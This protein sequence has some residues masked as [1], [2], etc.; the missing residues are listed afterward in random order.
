MASLSISLSI[1]VLL[2]VAQ[3]LISCVCEAAPRK[4]VLLPNPP[5][6]GLSYHN[7]PL[8]TGPSPLHL[9]FLWY[10][11]FSPAQKQILS[12]FASSVSPSSSIPSPSV[13]SWWSTA[14]SYTDSS[15][16]HVSST[17]ALSAQTSVTPSRSIVLTRESIASLLL[18]TLESGELP[19]DERGIYF[20]LTGEEVAVEGMCVSACGFHDHLQV[21]NT[22]SKQNVQEG[23]AHD[24]EDLHLQ[25][26]I[27]ASNKKASNVVFAWVGNSQRQCP[28]QCAWPFALP[29]YGPQGAAPLV[30]PNGDVGMD[31][32]VINLATLLVGAATNPRGAGYFQGPSTEPLEAASACTGIFGSGAYP[33]FPGI[34]RTD[35]H[36]GASFNVHGTNGRM[37]LL[38]SIWNPASQ[39]CSPPS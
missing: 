8:L 37:F 17:I 33:G 11:S 1:L 22:T 27:G 23:K 39:T 26:K 21:N 4:L 16:S 9:Y 7:G 29:E 13:S 28:G 24:N 19:I 18:H 35:H 25:V 34:L 12:D 6:A 3:F 10:G 32:M 15:H 36:S 20:V 2:A 31:G 5:L 38:P 14:A 30:P